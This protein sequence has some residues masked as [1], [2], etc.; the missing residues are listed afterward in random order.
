MKFGK[1][2]QDIFNE[3][4]FQNFENLFCLGLFTI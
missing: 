4:L 3:L 1:M 2:P